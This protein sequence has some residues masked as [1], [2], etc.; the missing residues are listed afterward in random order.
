MTK[1][2]YNF[3]PGPATLPLPALERAQK[4]M[5]DFQ[6][7]G[8]SILEISHRSKEY[9][10]V[11]NEAT[12][13]VRELM[14]V[15]DDYKILWLQGG[16]SSQ[17]FMVPVNLRVPGKPMQYVDTGTWSSKALKE[18]KLYGDVEIVAS[19]K[20]EKFTYV[21]KDVKFSGNAAFAHITSNNTIYGTAYQ[22]WPDVPSDVPLVVDMSSDLMATE[23]DVRKFGVIYA[24]AQKNLGPAGVT[25][26]II[27][28]DLLDRVPEETPTLLKWKTEA[29][30]NSLFHTPPVFSIYLS[31]LAMDYWKDFGGV[32]TIEKVNREKAKILYDVIDSSDGFYKGHARKDSRSLMNVTFTMANEDI[33]KQCVAE[34]L[35]RDLVGLKGHRSVGGMRASIYNAMSIDGVK[36]LASHLTEFKEKNQ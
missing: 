18:A 5:L 12:D 15:P 32:K 7:T 30:K 17:F 19:S 24:G 2:V 16:A 35:S 25:L 23:I 3:Y 8:M 11:H 20:D 31:K 21:P 9:D 26:V 36:A 28:E 13:L 10:K 1:R 33:E 34:G 27:R 6:G 29:E 14:G 22:E 4:E